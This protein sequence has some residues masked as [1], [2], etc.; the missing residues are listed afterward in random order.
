MQIPNPSPRAVLALVAGLTGLVLALPANAAE[1]RREQPRG[2][3]SGPDVTIISFSGS[4]LGNYGSFA[5]IHAYS[6][7]TT[8]CNVGNQPVWW[9]DNNTAYCGSDQH[10]VIAQN[11]YRL[12]DGR[13]EQ[14][15]MSWLKHGFL[16]TNSQSATCLPG[17][18]CTTP[19]HGGDQLGV[20][21]TD[22]YGA[23]LNGSRPLGMR[24]EVNATT[25]GFPFPYTVVATNTVIDQRLQ[26]DETDLDPALNAGARY[27]AEG[28]YVTAD[29]AQAGNGLNNA[30]YREVLV[31]AGP[32]YD[33]SFTGAMVREQ[34]AIRVWPVID[35]AVRL[36]NVDYFSKI[37]QRFEIASRV[38]QPQAGVWHY[39]VAVHNLNSERSGR[40]LSFDFPDGAQISNVGFHDVDHHSGE[41]Y[42]TTD[43]T[44]TVDAAHATVRWETESWNADHDANALRWGTTFSFWFDVD[45]G[46]EP[47]GSL[48]LFAPDAAAD[49]VPLRFSFPVILRPTAAPSRAPGPG[50][51]T[52]QST[53]SLAD[54]PTAARSQPTPTAPEEPRRDVER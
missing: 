33:I 17:I 26:I 35:P 50:A 9:C 34:S 7:G 18:G 46:A 25:G 54:R 15:G 42:A 13:F 8:S 23:S 53:S 2:Q 47:V 30:S 4:S 16:S 31:G 5:G 22:T 40:A 11:L 48:E 21:C 29:D 14:I 43:W 3:T 49:T 44:S 10:P 28:Q 36:I 20:G 32:G 52:G 51:L 37:V 27:F 45:T 38:T 39:E 24:S 1:S 12:K 19:P 6:I 41:P